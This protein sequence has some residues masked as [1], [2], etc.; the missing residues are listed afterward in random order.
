MRHAEDYVYE[1]QYFR[2]MISSNFGIVA[3]FKMLCFAYNTVFTGLCNVYIWQMMFPMNFI[4]LNH[5]I[6]WMEYDDNS[7]IF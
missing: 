2:P 3:E 6:N 4:N 5:K 7:T 1:Y